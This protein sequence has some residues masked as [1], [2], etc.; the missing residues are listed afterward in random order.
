[1]STPSQD[2]EEPPVP[3]GCTKCALDPYLAPRSDADHTAIS[4]R[5]RELTVLAYCAA[6]GCV[7]VVLLAQ[8]LV[9]DYITVRIR[10]YPNEVQEY[11]W[12]TMLFPLLPLLLLILAR[13]RFVLSGWAITGILVGGL[14][15]F[16]PLAV[17]LGM[18]FHF[19]IGGS[20]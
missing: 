2:S 16:L 5:S 8:F 18:W 9:L 19:A 12:T 7:A 6:I 4:S 15:L 3:G 20:L 11:D 14:A 13:R 17:T 1:M 10:P